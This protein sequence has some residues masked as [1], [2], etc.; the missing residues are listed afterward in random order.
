MGISGR[1]PF[2][3][4]TLGGLAL[5]GDAGPLAGAAAQRRSLALLALLALGRNKGVSR[6]KLVAY[7]WPESGEER[8]HHALAQLLYGL[9]RDL[10]KAD[11]AAGTTDLR[12]NRDVISVD[13]DD[14]ETA[15]AGQDF[16]RAVAA[17]GG[18]L[19]DGFHLGGAPEFERLVDGERADLAKRMGEALKALAEVASGRGD[20]VAAVGWWRRLT[21]LDPLSSRAALGLMR[22]LEAAGDR[23]GALQHAREH[24]RIVRAELD[25]APDALITAFVAELRRT[26]MPPPRPPEPAVASIAVLPF[27]NLGPDPDTEYVSDGITEE[28]IN[29]LARVA[30]LRVAARMSA[31]AFKGS[32][33][34]VRDVAARLNVGTVLE[35][36]VRKAGSQ[37]RIAAQLINA[38]DGYHLW[39]ETYDRELDDVFAVQDELARAIAATLARTL[40]P[41][42]RPSLVKQATSSMP[43]YLLYLRGRHYLAKRTEE[44]LRKAIELFELA[45]ESDPAYAVAYAG[46]ANAYILLGFDEYRGLPPEVA[47]PRGKAA[48]QRALE[49]DTTLAE[50]H[51][52]LGWVSLFYEWDWGS[53]ERELLRAVAAQPNLAAGH[54]WYALY[55]MAMGR[56]D[57]SIAEMQRALALDPLFPIV[58]TNLGRAYAFARRFDEAVAH[59]RL[60]LEMEPG[61][62]PAQFELARVLA[63][64]GAFKEARAL[65]RAAREGA[66]DSV[67]PLVAMAWVEARAG[68]AAARTLLAELEERATR[69]YVPHYYVAG[70]YAA[71]G[72]RERAIQHLGRACDERSGYAV[73]LKVEM[74]HDLQDDPRFVELLKRVGLV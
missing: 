9:R 33:A 59:Y 41:G 73:F 62:L 14:F 35:G 12:L 64:Q 32:T 16:E 31:F 54:H 57:E 30:G 39:S 63:L 19:L 55:L 8:A 43:A 22:A 11:V 26:P 2:R 56:A 21:V 61:F 6:D 18:P 36:S 68:A 69:E 37:V 27:V 51:A 10:G 42:P 40:V 1:P 23:G 53:A 71:L 52:A 70:A 67:R 72:D 20:H 60:A 29:A 15:L 17:Y 65:C 38:A 49:L 13:L 24:G 74:F 3:L 46:L 45:I 7:L 44:S 47:M 5:A 50:A 4:T 58:S 66:S 25:A 28:L 48:A 34:D